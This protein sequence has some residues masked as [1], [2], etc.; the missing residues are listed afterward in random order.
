[1]GKRR[2]KRGTE[3][4]FLYHFLLLRSLFPVPCPLNSQFFQKFPLHSSFQRTCLAS[5]HGFDRF[6]L[7]ARERCAVKNMLFES[8]VSKRRDG[9]R[10]FGESE[11]EFADF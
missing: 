9:L 3:K 11:R 8:F 4:T 5:K 7:P 2:L 1:M 10:A 6:E